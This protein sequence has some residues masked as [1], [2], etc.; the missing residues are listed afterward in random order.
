[1]MFLKGCSKCLGDIHLN[2][3]AYGQYIACLQ[4][5]Y[6][7]DVSDGYKRPLVRHLAHQENLEAA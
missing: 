6:M 5:G 7:K 1:M 2:K 4:C 3:D